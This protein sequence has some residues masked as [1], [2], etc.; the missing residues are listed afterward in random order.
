MRRAIRVVGALI[1]V[2]V[3]AMI[4]GF[5]PLYWLLY[6]A[7]AG[8]VVGYLWAWVQSRGLE[9]DVYTLSPHPQV[10]Q[11]VHIR[12]TVREKVGLPR[13]G[14]RARLVGDFV[15][16]DEDEFSL[17]PQGTTSWTVSGL[18]RRRGL[19]NIGSLAIM[20]SDP[21][22]L[23]NLE[24]RVGQPQTTLVY[25]PT[26]DLSRTLIEG[27]VNGGE[28][29]ESGPLVGHSPAAFMVRQYIPGDSMTRIHW[30]TTARMNEL[31]TKEFEGTGIN[32]IWVFVDLQESVQVGT[33]E[34][35]TEEY[36]I[37]IAASLIKSLILNGHAVGLMTQGDQAYRFGPARDPNHMWSMMGA[38]A[39][40]RARGR[41]SLATLISEESGN[42]GPGS[43]AMIVGPGSGPGVSNL[44]QFLTRRG[45]LVVP[46]FLDTASFG[47]PLVSLRPSDG[48]AEIQD[49][50]FVVRRG[51]DLS[52]T[53][54]TVLDR[55]T[56]M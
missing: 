46:I 42:L 52:A 18:C 51:D 55:L 7:V 43:V 53:L 32:E 44:F 47:R 19:N 36:C 15:N 8:A 31:M 33:D 54:G 50:A 10:G 22:G 56:S 45:V 12:V 2:L 37:T 16:M 48:R 11:T 38:L 13:M 25:P 39:V 5:Q 26:V 4:T 23:A 35:G 34:D 24:C 14:L 41:T 28:L 9:T 17:R 3:L 49:S 30:P 40:A 6:V 21:S 27:Q 20:S 1:T 29:G